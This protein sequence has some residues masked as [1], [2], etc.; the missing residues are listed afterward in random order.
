VLAGGLL[1][2]FG[3]EDQRRAYLP[4]IIDGSELWAVAWAEAQGRHDLHDIGLRAEWRGD[5]YLLNGGKQVVVG[6]PWADRLMVSARTAGERRDR[7]GITLFIVDKAQ[8]GV[9]CRDHTTVDGRRAAEIVFEDVSVGPEA[10]V[11]SEGG[12]LP[13]LECAVDHAIAALCA[14]AVGAM[15]EL[16]RMTRDYARLRKQFGVQLVKF[17]TLCSTAWSTCSWPTNRRCR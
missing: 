3:S 17:Q 7:N 6:A 13:G 14:E 11:G 5:A 9:G 1:R 8:A 4:R 10:R 15:D 16:N 2:D 12:G